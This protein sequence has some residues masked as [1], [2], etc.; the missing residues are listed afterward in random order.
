MDTFVL[1]SQ[2]KNPVAGHQGD[3]MFVS[4]KIAQNVAK[5]LF[6]I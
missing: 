6:F 3:Q 4:Q 2:I 5:T 1:A